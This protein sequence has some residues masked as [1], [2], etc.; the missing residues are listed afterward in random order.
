MRAI[1]CM[2]IWVEVRRGL[3]LRVEGSSGW[4]VEEEE[5]GSGL[6]VQARGRVEVEDL[7][8]H[9][10]LVLNLNHNLNLKRRVDRPLPHR[11]CRLGGHPILR[12]CI[13]V[14]RR[15]TLGGKRGVGV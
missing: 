8:L 14:H 3:H 4:V 6:K 12:G 1:G 10:R 5:E 15:P 9:L 2:L 11:V 7:H 13:R